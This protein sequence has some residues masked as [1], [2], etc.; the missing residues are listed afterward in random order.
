[1]FDMVRTRHWHDIAYVIG[2]AVSPRFLVVRD[3]IPAGIG[4][5]W[6]RIVICLL[7]FLD[8]LLGGGTVII[9]SATSTGSA[10]AANDTAAA[11]DCT[12]ATSSTTAANNRSATACHRTRDCD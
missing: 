12:T 5:L 9:A 1:M 7:P 4:I 3:L 6:P 2:P 10:T 8:E 11:D